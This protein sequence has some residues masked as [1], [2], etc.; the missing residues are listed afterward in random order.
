MDIQI[1]ESLLLVNTPQMLTPFNSLTVSTELLKPTVMIQVPP[2][3]GQF[4]SI[5]E[6]MVLLTVQ[7][8]LM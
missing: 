5:V 3:P 4:L 2:L 8:L 7:V 1:P 6:K